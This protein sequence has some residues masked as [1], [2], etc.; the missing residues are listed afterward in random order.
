[1][2]HLPT[3]FL[4]LAVVLSAA[5]VVGFLFRKMRQPQ[6]VGEM[7]AG[8]LLGPSLLGWVAPGAFA[9]IFPPDSLGFLNALS[10]FGLVIF[11]FLV[12]LEL[13]PGLV[14]KRKSETLAT[15][16]F[17]IAVPFVMS[18]A[19]AIYLYPRLSDGSVAFPHFALFMGIAMSITAFPVLARI[20]T[21][22]KLVN[23]EL[24]AISLACAAFNDVTGWS[25]LA[26]VVLL[27]RVQERAS[28]IWLL[29]VGSVVYVLA[30]FFVV[31]PM[32]RKL[33]TLYDRRGTVS[34]DNLAM[35]VVLVL[36]SGWVTEQLGV[37]ALFGAFLMG[38]IMPKSPGFS[39]ELSAK[40][41]DAAVVLLLPLFFAFTGL[42]TSVGLLRGGEMWLYLGIIVLV[43]IAGKF[44][45][46]TI[47][48]RLAGLDWRMASSVGILMNTRGLMELVVLNIGL[49]LG[50]L[51]SALFAMMVLMA[52]LTTFM[53]APVLEWIYFRR[54]FPNPAPGQRAE[55]PAG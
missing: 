3:L 4:Q 9:A 51:S 34:K 27:V 22:R 14:R 38:T 31:R 13:E 5:R 41:H 8:I 49:E 10:Q 50:I 7:F 18:V 48:A 39:R 36:A 29:L 32:L 16:Y 30:M 23:S 52:L 1:M 54:F 26:G 25:I 21:E 20:L 15:A 28:G 40:L 42:R 37:H 45:G 44:G 11:M 53:T 47:A 24:G 6:V 17:S 43:A 33:V 35:V 12:G 19:L 2:P 55:T 46:A